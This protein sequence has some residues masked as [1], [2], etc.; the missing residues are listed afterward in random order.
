MAKE[1]RSWWKRRR[2]AHEVSYREIKTNTSLFL[3]WLIFHLPA[4]TEVLP[5]LIYPPQSNATTSTTT[6]VSGWSRHSPAGDNRLNLFHF[7]PQALKYNPCG[8][9][10][11]PAAPLCTLPP[12]PPPAL[13]KKLAVA[14][15][16]HWAK[17]QRW[18][19][20]R[21]QTIWGNY[22]VCVCVYVCPGMCMWW[23]VCVYN[24]V[25]SA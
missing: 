13:G 9:P 23:L 19:P 18:R 20:V 7:M 22:C 11:S 4:G 21:L 5:S 17:L 25:M 2:E 15:P 10:P 12:G 1:G 24:G 3:Y 6:S 14:A 16:V 8:A